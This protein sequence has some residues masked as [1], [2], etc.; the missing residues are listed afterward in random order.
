MTDE[1]LVVRDV[2]GTLQFGTD[3]ARA[4]ELVEGTLALAPWEGVIGVTRPRP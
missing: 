4:G 3:G 1:P 2:D